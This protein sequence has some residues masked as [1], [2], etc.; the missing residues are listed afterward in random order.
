[1]GRR[2][3]WHAEALA[4]LAGW[5]AAASWRQQAVM[6]VVVVAEGQI[7]ARGDQAHVWGSVVLALPRRWLSADL[8]KALAVSAGVSGVVVVLLRC[9]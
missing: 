9:G 6:M 1:M 8:C 4:E 3:A 2:G 7:A 5:S